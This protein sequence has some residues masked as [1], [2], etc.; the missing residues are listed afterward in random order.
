MKNATIAL[1]GSAILAFALSAEQAKAS[2][3]L[4]KKNGCIACHAIDKKVVGPAWHDV[5]AKY[6]G[7]A[8]AAQ[9]LA[10]KVKAGGKGV[11]GQVAMP[12]QTQVSD[13]D[14]KAILGWVL[15]R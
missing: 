5:A 3:E 9:T 11:W 14:L 15:S 7:N 6:K 1:L 10:A 4:V 13:A 12:P 2:E 8:K